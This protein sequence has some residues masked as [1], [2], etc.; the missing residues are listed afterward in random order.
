M[1]YLELRGICKDYGEKTNCQHILKDVSLDVE[2]GEMVSIMGPSGSGKS[3]LLHILG[4]LDSQTSGEYI[5]QNK[6]MDSMK[7]KERAF[8]R[9]EHIG[10]VFQ[11][12]Q[13]MNELSALDNVKLTL[14][15]S[16]LYKRNKIRNK[17]AVERSKEVLV[18]LGL[19]EH[20]YKYPSQLSGGQQQRVAIARAIV[21][22]PDLLLADE[23]TGAL[24]S[25]TTEEIMQILKQL[26][27][28][29]NTL[30]I[31][32]HNLEVAKQCNRIIRIKDGKIQE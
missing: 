30:I 32:T 14:Q 13:L 20:L 19:K 17:E 6:Y 7:E 22:H 11:G 16:N 25:V 23:P 18:N 24:D 28:Q 8:F 1:S 12:F 5:L 31:V 4:L 15:L 3:T 10:F 21:N 27:Q 9:N 29:G 2:C 26:N